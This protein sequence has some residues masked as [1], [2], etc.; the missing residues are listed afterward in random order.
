MLNMPYFPVFFGISQSGGSWLFGLCGWGVGI[1]NTFDIE[2]IKR[3]TR[4]LLGRFLI[5]GTGVAFGWGEKIINM[6]NL[7]R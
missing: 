1:G 4:F 7:F 6:V 2:K 5:L 3:L